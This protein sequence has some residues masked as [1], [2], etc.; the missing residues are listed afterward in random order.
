MNKQDQIYLILCSLFSVIL[1]TG[2]LIYQKFVS[3]TIFPAYT[4][5]LSVG[6]LAYPITFFITD[7]IAEIYG[8]KKATYCVRIAMIMNIFI[9]LFITIL[10]YLPAT[11]WSKISDNEFH[12]MFG[13]FNLAFLSSVIA[14]YVAQKFDIIIYLWLK[15]I[16]ND[17]HLW[18]RSNAST[19]VSLFI[20]TSL[21]IGMLTLFEIIPASKTLTLIINSYSYKLFFTIC[22]TPLFY[23]SV[24][25][26]KN[27]L[28]IA[29]TNRQL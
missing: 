5:E 24:A 25:L 12:K 2:N 10:D 3:I 11:S 18:L 7:L 14:C 16:T 21:V 19:T 28:K 20:D 1:V 13:L 9:A 15:K 29:Y 27:R 26:V 23:L 6:A 4:F 22:C 17:K 8:K